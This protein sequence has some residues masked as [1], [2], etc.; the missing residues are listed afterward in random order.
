MHTLTHTHTRTHIPACVRTLTTTNTCRYALQE[1]GLIHL[2]FVEPIDTIGDES[3]EVQ[4]DLV[5]TLPPEYPEYAA[6]N[7]CVRVMRTS[8][9]PV[10]A[11]CDCVGQPVDCF[12]T[13]H[14][15]RIPPTFLLENAARVR[16]LSQC[17]RPICVKTCHHL[18]LDT[19]PSCCVLN[20]FGATNRIF[21]A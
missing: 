5:L 15:C 18:G 21:T 6:P 9:R 4:V 12:G 14:K 11:S 2:Q 16:L 8:S 17:H 7:V 10:Q 20:L 3:F 13:Q 19:T 1:A